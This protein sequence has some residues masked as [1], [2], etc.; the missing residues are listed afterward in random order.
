MTRIIVDNPVTEQFAMIPNAVW[1]LECSI[2]AK[3]ILSY[4][5]SFRHMAAPSVRQIESTLRI[6]KKA[7]LAAFAE[8]VELKLIRWQYDHDD[9][10][11]IVA[12]TLCVTSRPLLEGMG[13]K[14]VINRKGQKGAIGT[15]SAISP[16]AVKRH[17]H[18]AKKAPTRGQNGATYFQNE[19]IKKEPAALN[20]DDLKSYSLSCL[21]EG[22]PMPLGDGS[23]LNPIDPLYAELQRQLKERA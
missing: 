21:R 7:R 10:G 3:A 18:G 19:N 4:L 23:Q 5:L 13:E 1:D 2:K 6:G 9:K 22:K 8:L 14:E 15:E 20:L 17:R 16:L 12:Q 11:R